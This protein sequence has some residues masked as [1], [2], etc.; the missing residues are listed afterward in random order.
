MSGSHDEVTQPLL[1]LLGKLDIG[2]VHRLD[3]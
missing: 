3:F 1:D 2:L